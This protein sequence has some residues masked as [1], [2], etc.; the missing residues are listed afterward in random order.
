MA[1]CW[2]EFSDSDKLWC[3]Q[4]QI[5]IKHNNRR[6]W[7]RESGISEWIYI[8]MLLDS[9]IILLLLFHTIFDC[10]SGCV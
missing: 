3:E 2:L 7:E 10:V 8:Y 9:V 5:N 6:E 4:S 1:I